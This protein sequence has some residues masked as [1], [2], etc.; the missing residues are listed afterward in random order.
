M[1]SGGAQF[2]FVGLGDFPVGLNPRGGFLFGNGK[3]NLRSYGVDRSQDAFLPGE[4][5]STVIDEDRKPRGEEEFGFVGVEVDDEGLSSVSACFVDEGGAGLR[6]D[7]DDCV[8]WGWSCLAPAKL[9]LS[10]SR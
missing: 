1:E 4:V 6:L 10:A 3:G 2:S 7:E 5:A 8:L 9:M